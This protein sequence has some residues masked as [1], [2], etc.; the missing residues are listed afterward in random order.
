[1]VI[2]QLDNSSIFHPSETLFMHVV[3]LLAL[4][5]TDII[6]LLAALT[7]HLVILSSCLMMIWAVSSK[8]AVVTRQ[9]HPGG[10][11][12]AWLLL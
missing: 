7:C 12:S 11:E 4:F 10:R 3:E 9:V 1:M 2:D 6:Y 8:P 5:T